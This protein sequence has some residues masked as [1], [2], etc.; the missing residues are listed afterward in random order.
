MNR[1]E[2]R[3]KAEEHSK[4]INRQGGH[5]VTGFRMGHSTLVHTV[6]FSET[7]IQKSGNRPPNNIISSF[8]VT[9]TRTFTQTNTHTNPS[10]L[11]NIHAGGKDAP[12]SQHWVVKS[13]TR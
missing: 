8:K 4:V 10:T 1:I 11:E 3:A 12:H 9:T 6:W 7:T 13:D 5:S 2:G